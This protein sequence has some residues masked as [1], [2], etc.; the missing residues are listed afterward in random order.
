[1]SLKILTVEEAKKT[2]EIADKY[3][4][5]CVYKVGKAKQAFICDHSGTRIP[6]HGECAAVVILP[7]KDHPNAQHQC[8]MMD[9]Y[10]EE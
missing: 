5:F 4:E 10:I 3:G 9:E 1:M 7:S 2:Q 8:D 6:L